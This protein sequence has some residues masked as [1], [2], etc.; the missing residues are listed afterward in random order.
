MN[1]ACRIAV[2]RGPGG[3]T[4]FGLLNGSGPLTPRRTGPQRVHLVA[5]AGGPLGGD[6]Y[7]LDI[8]VGPGARL[9]VCSAAAS[10]VL[11]AGP[12]RPSRLTV[13]AE[14]AEGGQLEL[15][16]APVVLSNRGLHRASTTIAV[17]D[18]ARLVARELVVL[19]RSGETG[20]QGSFATSLDVAGRPALRQTVRLAPDAS[21]RGP[22]VLAGGRALGQLLLVRPDAAT[23]VPGGT[24]SERAAWLPLAVPGCAVFT[25]TAVDPADAVAC[26]DRE[27]AELMGS[28]P[29]TSAPTGSG[30]RG[31]SA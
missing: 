14:V 18:G 9:E 24:R 1:A 31:L 23:D 20:G 13:R 28:D 29:T 12:G 22:A 11:A 10:I 21:S 5:A 15:N 6:D 8:R 27:V 2:D 26:L 7:T 17:A 30:L 4:R 19:G 3:R 16:P 25:V